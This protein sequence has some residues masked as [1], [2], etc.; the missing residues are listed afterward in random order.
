V[1]PITFF[2]Q[3]REELAKVSWPDRKS[4]LSMTLVVIGVSA[5][6]G[7]YVGGLDAL[8]T[9]LFNAIIRQ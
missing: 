2:H 6:V 8:F 4:A 5:A 3:V 1:N 9:T 7:L